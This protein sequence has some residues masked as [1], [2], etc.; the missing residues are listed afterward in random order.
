MP[1]RLF[2]S[3]LRTAKAALGLSEEEIRNNPA[4]VLLEAVVTSSEPT[5]P[6]TVFVQD[7]TAGIQVHAPGGHDLNTGDKVRLKGAVHLGIFEPNVYLHSYEKLGTAPL[8]KPVPVAIDQLLIS[9]TGRPHPAQGCL[10]GGARCGLIEREHGLCMAG[11]AANGTETVARF[12]ELRPD[13]CVIDLRMPLK[14]GVAAIR[15]IRSIDPGALILVLSSHG[16]DEDIRQALDAGAKGYVLKQGSG[17][18]IIPAI[19]ALIAG[20]R[21]MP[22]EVALR[23]ERGKNTETLTEREHHVLSGLARGDANKEI[24]V[25]LR[26]T[27]HTVKMHVKNILAKLAVRDR[28]EAVPVALRRGILTLDGE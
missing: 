12:I 6:K 18:Q 10:P 14:S 1:V 25:G 4:T 20:N 16:G 13:L 2:A 7:E 27:E 23:F 5:W 28:T 26:I 15:E 24:A 9:G 11:E 3:E 17:K 8:P 21:W 22:M 19:R